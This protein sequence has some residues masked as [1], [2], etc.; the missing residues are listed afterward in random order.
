MLAEM[1]QLFHPRLRQYRKLIAW[2]KA[3]QVWIKRRLQ[4]IEA[5]GS[6]RA[7]DRF[8]RDTELKKLMDK[9][10]VTMQAELKVIEKKIAEMSAPHVP[11]ALESMKGIGPVLQASLMN[12]L[13]ELG[14]LSAGK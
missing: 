2:R 8:L 11:E 1:A 9:P 6:Q 14:T 7:N 13:P 12:E 10:V 4:V 3:L 5:I